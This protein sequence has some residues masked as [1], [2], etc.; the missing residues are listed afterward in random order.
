[1]PLLFMVDLLVGSADISLN[2][3]WLIL[4]GDSVNEANSIILLEARLPKAIIAVLAGIALSI[5]GLLMQNLFQN[6]LAGPY[7]LGIS[8]GAGLGVA[9]LIMGATFLGFSIGV[10]WSI[11]LAAMLGSILVLL[12]LFLLSTRIKDIMTLL[13]LGVMIGAIAT[14]LIGILQFFSTEIQLKS[15][16]LW[17][18]GS[19]ENVTNDELPLIV[20]VVSVATVLVF[21]SSKSM[22]A[23]LLGEE[24]AKSIGVSIVRNRLL[25]ILSSGC[26][27]GVITAYCGP[28]G[29][30]GIVVPHLCRLWF[31]TTDHLKLIP[32]VMLMGASVLLLSD[33]VS[34]LPLEHVKLPINSITAL[35][36]IPIILWIILNRRTISSGF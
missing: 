4:N 26:L 29:F 28:I 24:Y 19:L 11:T 33:V 6:P 15:F 32:A 30:I 3:I 21:I 36:G 14:A 23:L 12:V 17:T 10:S 1:M 22:N 35:L 34:T 13:I 5:S 16:M 2:E 25:I 27:A 20:I 7:I 9:V 8:S 31:Q 18:L